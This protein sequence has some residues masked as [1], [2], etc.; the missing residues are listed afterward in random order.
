MR[1]KRV[2]QVLHVVHVQEAVA[3]PEAVLRDV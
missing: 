2:A 3:E 1:S